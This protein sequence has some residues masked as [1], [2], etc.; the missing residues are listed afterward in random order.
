MS[1]VLPQQP[2]KLDLSDELSAWLIQLRGQR[3]SPHT[4]DGYGVA[5]RNYL[6][7]CAAQGIQAELTKPNVIGFLADHAGQSSTVRLQLTVLKLFA[8]W[9]ATE[10]EGF[11]ADPV[12][13]VKGPK[14]DE[15]TV[16]D[17]HD[18]EIRRMIKACGD[19]SLR[20][21]RDKAILVLFTETGL[22]SAELLALDVTDVDVVSCTVHVRRG[23]GGK[24]RHARFSPGCAALIDRYRRARRQAGVPANEGPLWLS[25]RGARRLTYNGMRTSLLE[26]AAVAGVVGFHPHRL[27]HS[28]AVRWL[29]QGGT[30]QGLMSQSGWQSRTMIDRYVKS[31]SAQLAA[32]EFDRL[33]LGLGDI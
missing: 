7:W 22:R 18:D 28:S 17:L 32:E 11:D 29:R 2:P 25:E 15:K 27:R 13:A 9:L 3:K 20:D 1:E 30:E 23:K 5:V 10:Y 8:K 4:R 24:G 14:T 21:K 6:R 33:G 12:L 16:P 31:A 26:R 19:N